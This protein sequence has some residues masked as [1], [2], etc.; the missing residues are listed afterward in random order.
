M[1]DRSPLFSCG[2]FMWVLLALSGCN[3]DVTG[4]ELTDPRLFLTASAGNGH[5]CAL[6]LDGRTLCWGRNTYGQLGDGT[7]DD[8][9]IPTPAPSSPVFEVLSAGGSHTC[10]LTPEGTAY[11]WGA[12]HGGQLGIGSEEDL[13]AQPTLVN[14]DA[15]F[16]LISAGSRHTC[17]VDKQGKVL[18]WGQNPYG[19]I[20]G[21]QEDD[22]GWSL[23]ARSPVEVRGGLRFKSVSVGTYH[24][25]GIT[26]AGKIQCWGMNKYGQLGASTTELCE[27]SWG[28][29]YPCSATPVPLSSSLAWKEVS[30]DAFHTCAL[31]EAG[32]VYCWG[33]NSF[34][35]LGDGSDPGGIR[36]EP[37]AVAG[38][39]TFAGV[40]AGMSSCGIT[41][42]GKAYCWGQGGLGD[43]TWEASSV[44]IPVAAPLLF[45]A[46]T[47]GGT[48]TCGLSRE[49]ILYCWGRNRDGQLGDG[50][51]SLGWPIPVAVKGW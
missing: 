15:R 3:D 44:P 51:Y 6:T 17:A 28:D 49:G 19:G 2:I 14:T 32:A 24:T 20:G 40:S 27:D 42:Q 30:A 4:P 5:T 11:C 22:C 29:P 34:G 26:R 43:G 50:S 31:S 41:P 33:S 16:V 10:G 12:N 25:C 8:R 39:M 35:R 46:V 9:N 13:K 1:K 7:T 37:A 45:T 48:H 36:A 18:C 38:E 47:A 23:C 21:P